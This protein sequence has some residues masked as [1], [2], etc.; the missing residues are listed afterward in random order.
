MDIKALF[1]LTYG[2][3]VLG[4]IDVDRAD[5]PV[6]CIINTAVQITATP[7]TLAVSCNKD[8]YTNQCIAKS[9]LF[10]LSILTENV[11]ESIIGTFG[12]SSSKD[13]NKYEGL[14]YFQTANGLPVLNAGVCSYLECK[15]INKVDCYTH[16]IFIAEIVDAKILASDKPM[17]YDYYH[18]VIKGKAPKN[19]PTYVPESSESAAY[20]C[21]VCG[22]KYE[23]NFE[24]LDDNYI[25]P[26]C[27]APKGKFVLS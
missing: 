15:V 17:T 24:E 20:K 6:G 12:F 3:H 18:R 8:N 1:N 10:T 14:S 23:G 7:S 26:I 13:K 21:S 22:Y 2:L 27:S 5:A 4:S 11:N 16:T 19:A 9:S 25:C